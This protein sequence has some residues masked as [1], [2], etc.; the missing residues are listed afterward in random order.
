MHDT[1]GLLH[2][3][4]D[5]ALFGIPVFAEYLVVLRYKTVEASIFLEGD[6]QL[7]QIEV[8]GI[9]QALEEESIH[10][11]GERLIP[12]ANAPVGRDIKYHGVSRDVLR[13]VLEQD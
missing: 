9:A 1:A 7:G 13:N 10:D 2:G 11:L 12:A 3:E 8:V 4:C 6:L 5:L